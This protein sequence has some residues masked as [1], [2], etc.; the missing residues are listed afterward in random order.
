MSTGL[1]EPLLCTAVRR[2]HIFQN[3][4]FARVRSILM[5]T[6]RRMVTLDFWMLVPRDLKHHLNLA[7]VLVKTGSRMSSSQNALKWRCLPQVALPSQARSFLVE[8][9]LRTSHQT[10]TLS[11]WLSTSVL[12]ISSLQRHLSNLYGTLL[13]NSRRRSHFTAS[14]DY[15]VHCGFAALQSSMPP[16]YAP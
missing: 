4:F 1:L 11:E 8:I 3:A 9:C 16:T 5:E 2:I 14:P 10:P 12:S 15:S 6:N 7:C 13:R